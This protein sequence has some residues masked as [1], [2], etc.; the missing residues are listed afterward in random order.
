[1]QITRFGSPT[2]KKVLIGNKADQFENRTRPDH[3]GRRPVST[4]EAKAVADELVRYSWLLVAMRFIGCAESE[5]LRDGRRIAHR[6][7]AACGLETKR[8]DGRRSVGTDRC[9]ARRA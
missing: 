5:I 2:A 8:E 3:T 7:A 9:L 6:V 1:M 4:A